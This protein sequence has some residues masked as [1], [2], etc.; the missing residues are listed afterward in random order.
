MITVAERKGVEAQIVDVPQE[1]VQIANQGAADDLL[2]QMI[3]NLQNT[4]SVTQNPTLIQ[5]VLTQG[6]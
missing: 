2:S 5:R 3:V 6:H 1:Q 4:Y